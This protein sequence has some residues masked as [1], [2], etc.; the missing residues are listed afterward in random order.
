MVFHK[1]IE[2]FIKTRQEDLK[3][4]RFWLSTLVSMDK[5]DLNTVD[6]ANYDEIVTEMTVKKLQKFANKLFAD[7]KNVEVIMLPITE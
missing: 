2:Y 5:Y 1:T 4:N 7:S 3:E 6:K